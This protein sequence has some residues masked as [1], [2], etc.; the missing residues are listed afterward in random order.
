MWEHFLLVVTVFKVQ[1]NAS[2]K[3]KGVYEK[4]SRKARLC[5]CVLAWFLRGFKKA[6]HDHVV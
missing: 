5:L 6:G 1:G 4:S 2:F 3:E